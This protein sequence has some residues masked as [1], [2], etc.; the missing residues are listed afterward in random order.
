MRTYLNETGSLV[1]LDIGGQKFKTT[2]S[3][4]QSVEGKTP[5]HLTY[6]PPWLSSR[7]LFQSLCGFLLPITSSHQWNRE[8]AFH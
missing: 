6:H 4:L 1:Y 8:K 2:L 5:I 7:P 3:T